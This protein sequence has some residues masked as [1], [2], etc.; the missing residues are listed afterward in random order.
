LEPAN[1]AAGLERLSPDHVAVAHDVLDCQHV[2][3]VVADDL[4]QLAVL[5]DAG[6]DDLA[7]VQDVAG[8]GRTRVDA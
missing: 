8:L 3:A 1:P 5:H 2:A 6:G 4:Q 7:V